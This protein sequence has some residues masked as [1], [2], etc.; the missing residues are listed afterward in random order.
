MLPYAHTLC[1]LERTLY[2]PMKT[3]LMLREAHSSCSHEE[4]LT[5]PRKSRL[6]LPVW[7]LKEKQ[8]KRMAGEELR[9]KSRKVI[10]YNYAMKYTHCIFM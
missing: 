4:S 3:L 6:M 7:E 10:A 5:A 2:A 8:E 1:F 9:E